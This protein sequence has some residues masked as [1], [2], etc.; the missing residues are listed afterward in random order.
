MSPNSLRACG[1]V[2]FQESGRFPKWGSVSNLGTKRHPKICLLQISPQEEM[3]FCMFRK[4]MHL[5]PREIS[6]RIPAL[7]CAGTSIPSDPWPLL[8]LRRVNTSAKSRHETSWAA[9][10]LNMDPFKGSCARYQFIYF[11]DT[12]TLTKGV[13]SKE[14]T[15]GY[16]EKTTHPFIH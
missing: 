14:E 7:H 16:S 5:S 15:K 9:G 4:V 6:L 12:P 10:V 11:G 3:H 13:P 1:C 8:H 2:L